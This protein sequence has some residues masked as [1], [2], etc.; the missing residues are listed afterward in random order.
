MIFHLKQGGYSSRCPCG[1]WV[2]PACWARP[3][4]PLWTSSRWL[5]WVAMQYACAAHQFGFCCKEMCRYNGSHIFIFIFILT[6]MRFISWGFKKLLG[7]GW[8]EV[9]NTYKFSHSL[10]RHV[11]RNRFSELT[12]EPFGNFFMSSQ[13]PQSTLTPST[14]LDTG[15]LHKVA[16]ATFAALKQSGDK[17]Q[18]TVSCWRG[19]CPP[20]GSLHR[21]SS[22]CRHIY[23]LSR[24][25]RPLWLHWGWWGWSD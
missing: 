18:L 25:R 15:Y 6:R 17:R 10:P 9:G 11:K 14:L 1:S 3:A 16:F 5:R 12:R 21:W 19:L 24:W 20:P 22:P 4:W 7:S 13:S 23:C 8:W 2:V